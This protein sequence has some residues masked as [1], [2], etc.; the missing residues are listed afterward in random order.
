M[1][2]VGLS[3]SVSQQRYS[4]LSV[5]GYHSPPG[6][7]PARFPILNTSGYG[8]QSTYLQNHNVY[9][10]Q[11][12]P[13]HYALSTLGQYSNS[14]QAVS[15]SYTRY[16]PENFHYHYHQYIY[17]IHYYTKLR[18]VDHKRITWQF[19]FTLFFIHQLFSS[20]NILLKYSQYHN[21]FR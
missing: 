18:T 5:P 4:A 14:Y 11:F 16:E 3:R 10:R 9:G 19:V 1:L 15:K 20:F 6:H 12:H 17:L 21:L 7:A 8:R 13:H 2:F